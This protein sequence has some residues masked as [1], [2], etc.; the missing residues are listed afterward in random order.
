MLS[1]KNI[2]QYTFCVHAFLSTMV[3]KMPINEENMTTYQIAVLF[4]K[5]G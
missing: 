1:K 5:G 2:K 3:C 4:S